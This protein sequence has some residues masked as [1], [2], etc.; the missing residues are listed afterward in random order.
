MAISQERLEILRKIEEY[1]ENGWFDRDVEDDPPTT[2]LDHTKVDYTGKRFSTRVASEIAN[3]FGRNHFEGMLKR[4]D[5]ILREIRGAEN[6]DAVKDCGALVTCNHFN[7]F[8]NYAAYKALE[9]MLGKK[10]LYKIIR[11]GNYTSFGGFYGYLF[12]HCN[13]LPLC[14]SISGMKALMNAISVLF[15][16]GEKILIYPEQGM[17]YNYR[18]PRPLKEGAF[19]FA[20]RD[21]V[22]VLPLFITLE[23]T[24]RLDGDGLPIQAYTV[25]ILPP[26]FPDKQK[27]VRENTALMCRKNYE[28]WVDVYE[29][30]YGK[31]L[32]YTTKG[33]DVGPCSI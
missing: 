12:R 27:S 2:P 13:T 33:G 1:E 25:H 32:E 19:R 14:S 8:D 11:E 26:I 30:F 16:R 28:M 15:E 24:E 20:A 5:V 22:P 17:W 18:K 29:S 4:G 7:A 10:R 3:I 23:D 9:P 21:N 31:K 6:F